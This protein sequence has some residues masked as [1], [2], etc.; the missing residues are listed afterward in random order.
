MP[1]LAL[2][3]FAQ[4]FLGFFG[5]LYLLMAVYKRSEAFGPLKAVWLFKGPAIGTLM[6][7]KNPS[8]GI[9]VRA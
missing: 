3:C 6:N 4:D 2:K 1:K 5:F 9:S 7:C 8:S